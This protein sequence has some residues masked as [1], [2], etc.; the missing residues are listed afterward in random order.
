[1]EKI[2][3][4]KHFQKSIGAKVKQTIS[5][6][7]IRYHVLINY[8]RSTQI[9]AFDFKNQEHSFFR[10]RRE[11]RKMRRKKWWR[12]RRRRKRRING[13]QRRSRTSLEGLG[14]GISRVI[15]DLMGRDILNLFQS[16]RFPAI[17]GFPHFPAVWLSGLPAIRLSAG[18]FH[19]PKGALTK[20]LQLK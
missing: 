15:E 8:V 10:L 16:L 1:M 20:C 17:S 7:Y 3:L 4:E 19:S 6:F 14:E 9:L 11:G 2:K 18:R 13:G 5:Q 12:S